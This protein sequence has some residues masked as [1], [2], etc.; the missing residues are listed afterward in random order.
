MTTSMTNANGTAQPLTGTNR[1]KGNRCLDSAK[2]GLAPV[3]STKYN[4]F[5]LRVSKAFF[6]KD[7][8][9]LE[10]IGQAF[11]LRFHQLH[12]HYHKRCFDYVRGRYGAGTVQQGELRRGL[13]LVEW[14]G[15][16]FAATQL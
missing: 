14:C 7:Q 3:A 8:R 6:V 4:D 13:L 2:F 11:N 15:R 16:T 10:L 12:V 9:Q 5:D 1:N